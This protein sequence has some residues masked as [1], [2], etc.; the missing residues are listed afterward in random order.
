MKFPASLYPWVYRN[1]ADRNERSPFIPHY[2]IDRLPSI[3]RNVEPARSNVFSIEGIDCLSGRHKPKTY[4]SRKCITICRHSNLLVVV[5]NLGQTACHTKTESPMQ[6]QQHSNRINLELT[7][8][9]YSYDVFY[10]NIIVIASDSNWRGVFISVPHS[11]RYPGPPPPAFCCGDPSSEHSS[12]VTIHNSP[13]M[14]TTKKTWNNM[15]LLMFSTKDLNSLKNII[16]THLKEC[17]CVC[18]GWI[19]LRY[20]PE[21]GPE[22]EWFLIRRRPQKLF[23]VSTSV[24]VSRIT[25]LLQDI[26]GGLQFH[27]PPTTLGLISL[28]YI[29]VYPQSHSN[30]LSISI[31]T[32]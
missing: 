24:L 23:L 27:L 15:C 16:V 8:N 2:A 30:Y 6:Q 12:W 14:M 21:N 25:L 11:S 29:S 1:I 19:Q 5:S 17:K 7:L 4:R 3:S 28:I 13:M 26:P 32:I 22:L 9:W 31:Q 20:S 18:V 10:I